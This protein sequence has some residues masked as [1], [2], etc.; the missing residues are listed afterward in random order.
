[1]EVILSQSD[2]TRAIIAFLESVS[3]TVASIRGIAPFPHAVFAVL[4]VSELDAYR[5]AGC[6]R[7]ADAH[8]DNIVSILRLAGIKRQSQQDTESE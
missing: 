3:E 1:M 8:P 2:T 4:S 6:T 5:R 7:N